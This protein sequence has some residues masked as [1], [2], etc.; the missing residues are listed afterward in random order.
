MMAADSEVVGPEAEKTIG[1]IV[2]HTHWDRAWYLPFQQFRVRLVR[3]I[4]RLL[5]ILDTDQA[6]LSFMLDGQMIVTEDYFEVR[7]EKRTVLERLVRGGRLLVGPWYVLPDE[8]LVSPE[9]FIRNLEIGMDMAQA[10]GGVMKVGYEPDA[11]GHIGQ[12]PQILAGFG[13]DNVVFWR[14]MGEEA[15]QL[16]SE[17]WWR[18]PDGTRALAIYLAGGYGLVSFLGYPH[19]GDEA[20][21]PFRVEWA[22]DHLTRAIAE[23]A[24]YANTPYLILMA[25]IDHTEANRNLPRIVQDA[26]EH[27]PDVALRIGSLPEYIE[28]VRPYSQGFG[29]F[30]GELRSG[31]ESY[32]LQQVYSTRIHLKQRNNHCQILLERYAEPLAAYAEILGA[33][34]QQ[35]FLDLAWRE[36]LKNHPHDDICGCSVDAVHREMMV[37]FER[38]SQVSDVLVLNALRHLA[39]RIALP[40]GAAAVCIFNPSSRPYTGTLLVTL[41]LLADGTQ[42]AFSVR[43]DH[44]A[45]VAHQELGRFIGVDVEVN[46]PRQSMFVDVALSLPEI[47]AAGYRTFTLGMPEGPAGTDLRASRSAMEN[48]HLRVFI[49]PDGTI[50]LVDRATGTSFEGLHMIEDMADVGDEYTYSPARHDRPLT[51]VDAKVDIEV[52]ASG[53]VRAGIRIRYRLAMPREIAE[54]RQRRSRETVDYVITTEA[55]LGAGER[56][57]DF[58]TRVNNHAKDHRLRIVFPTGLATETVH[59][60]GHF[61]VVE[62]PVALPSGEGWAEPPSPTAHQRTFVDTS[63]GA[64]GL[65]LF[66]VGLPEY[67]ARHGESGT[68]IALT[69]LRC[70]GWLSRSDLTTRPGPAGYDL[71]TPEAQ[72]QGEYEFRYAVAPHA[73]TW[74]TIIHDAHAMNAPCSVIGTRTTEGLLPSDV[75]HLHV[76][77]RGKE[78][79]VWEALPR[80]AELDVLPLSASFVSLEPASLVLSSVRTTRDGQGMIVRCYNPTSRTVIGHLKLFWKP[81]RAA[82]VD[83]LEREQE[84]LQIEDEGIRFTA[85][86]KAIVSMRCQLS[87]ETLQ[88][89][90]GST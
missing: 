32:V 33:D 13:I 80:S 45:L 4:D 89:R 20:D 88:V 14:G 87:E 49:N 58:V 79:I 22:R 71:P 85:G 50:R 56:R 90:N 44:G 31:A 17:F 11:F 66:N 75:P 77:A 35:A 19:R 84:E 3:L 63:D 74:E 5:S 12:L 40:D 25:G 30:C 36:L 16:G 29:E 60:D 65:A 37:R 53:P 81:E 28:N 43:D 1:I 55:W 15:R 47:P 83:F 62:R 6:F 67:E 78:P 68:E 48:D 64:V 8:F 39:N 52:L 41:K 61:D 82:R 54:D 26:A 9:S 38:V 2:A 18:A 69:L 70:V 24:P 42:D 86:T 73:G 27:M 72:C 23:L 59:V 7:P 57:L 46:R 21:M 76:H 10:L 34:S 51:N